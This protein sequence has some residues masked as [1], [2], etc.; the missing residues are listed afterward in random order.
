M[1]ALDDRATGAR[2]HWL[3]ETT[4]QVVARPRPVPCRGGALALLACAVVS[5]GCSPRLDWREI[6]TG[7]AGL[8]AVFPCRPQQETRNVPL[9]G[10]PVAL[11]LHVCRHEGLTFAVSHAD[12]ADPARV[13]A[14][15]S[16][17]RAATQ[18]NLQAATSTGVPDQGVPGMTP[19]PASGH[20][21]LAGRSPDGQPL[22]AEV[23]VFSRGTRVAQATLLG[24]SLSGAPAQAFFEG[25]RFAD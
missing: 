6:R 8:R 22:Q 14:A 1:F 25:L 12:V 7:A 21:R 19:Q 15:L 13:G 9:A 18:A 3:V 2:K 23:A 10:A 5:A 20:W 17:L 24:R 16:E 4:K 11:T